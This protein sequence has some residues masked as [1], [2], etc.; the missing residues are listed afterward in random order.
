MD[1]VIQSPVTDEQ[2]LDYAAPLLPVVVPVDP[3]VPSEALE[4]NEPSVGPAAPAAAPDGPSEPADDSPIPSDSE[5]HDHIPY[6]PY[7]LALSSNDLILL[8]GLLRQ[9]RNATRDRLNDARLSQLKQSVRSSLY[10]DVYRSTSLLK[11]VTA[12]V[13]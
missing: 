12:L 6:R 11:R 3:D 7:S 1:T 8:G 10:A 4:A 5:R 2:S 9:E 13:S